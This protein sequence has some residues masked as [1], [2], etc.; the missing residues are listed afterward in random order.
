MIEFIKIPP[1]QIRLIIID[2][3]ICNIR[4]I[5]ES[6][7]TST[8]IVSEKYILIDPNT[9]ILNITKAISLLASFGLQ[10]T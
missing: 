7:K 6:I 3:I 5:C 9:N 1:K 8:G 4:P 2:A 10:S